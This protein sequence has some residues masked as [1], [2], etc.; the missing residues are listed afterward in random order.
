MRDGDIIP[1][2]E[3]KA[4]FDLDDS[5]FMTYHQ[6]MTVI[7]RISSK[8]VLIGGQSMLDSKCGRTAL[9]GHGLF[10]DCLVFSYWTAIF[11]PG[12]EEE[13]KKI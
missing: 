10:I 2:T 8:G 7:G 4:E 13:R 6:F 5:S 11:R 1:F 3:I 9:W 12:R